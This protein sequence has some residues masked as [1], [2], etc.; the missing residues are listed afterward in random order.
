MYFWGVASPVHT[1]RLI[2]HRQL[3]GINLENFYDHLGRCFICSRYFQAHTSILL[4]V[5]RPKMMETNV[6]ANKKDY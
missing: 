5:I 6:K 3:G 4:P 1:S 2:R